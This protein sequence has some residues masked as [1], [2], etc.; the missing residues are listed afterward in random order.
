MRSARMLVAAVVA[1]AMTAC[2]APDLKVRGS[3][4]GRGTTGNVRG[5]TR[6][7][8][9]PD[10]QVRGARPTT[11]S[12]D[13]LNRTIEQFDARLASHPSDTEAAVGLAE[14]LMRQTRV[15]GNAGLAKRAEDALLAAL[16][17][18]PLH[19]SARRMLATT[20]LSE[21]RF[22][23]AVLEAQQCLSTRTNDAYV[24]GVIGDGH[25]ELGE[26][27][28][29][30]AAFERMMALKPNAAAYGRASYAR[31]LQG[32]LGGALTF[33][34]M[35]TDATSAQ[36]PES[37]AWHHTQLGHLLLAAGRLTDARREYAHAEFVFPGHPFAA[38]GLARVA[39]AEHDHAGAWRLVEAKLASSPT[40]SD[41]AFAGD[42]LAA[43][44]R[45]DEA[46]RYYQL[47]ESSWRTDA[48]EP[49]RLAKFLAERGRKIGEAVRIAEAA[50]A[51]RHDIFTDDALAWAYFQN[52]QLDSARAASLRARR[53]GSRDAD[54]LAHAA[55]I[56][57][58]SQRQR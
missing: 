4:N 51:T 7:V 16:K 55:A 40:P 27:P 57:A 53:T 46:E 29:A 15:T 23:E 37:L 24:Y 56:D 19:Y 21:H 22:R 18:D 48:P 32:D 47:A 49:A 31:E 52:G 33:M 50:A 25:L 34:R 13:D 10:L 42:L 44:G 9:A 14:A 11:T 43:L 41:L 17:A 6:P 54:I 26:Y 45:A 3:S 8:G 35:A 38:D 2:S 39:A 20:Y 12:R 30:F 58:A 5:S 28:E 36:D 1:L